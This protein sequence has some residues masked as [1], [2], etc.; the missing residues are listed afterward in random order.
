MSVV[1]LVYACDWQFLEGLQKSDVVGGVYQQLQGS[2]ERGDEVAISLDGVLGP[3][4]HSFGEFGQIVSGVVDRISSS[5]EPLTRFS[6]ALMCLYIDTAPELL[7]KEVDC[8]DAYAT[9]S[10]E[11]VILLAGVCD[12]IEFD[13]LKQAYDAELTSPKFYTGDMRQVSYENFLAYC[14]GWRRCLDEAIE[15]AWGLVCIL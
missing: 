15:R 11:T 7:I 2:V 4:R 14:D 12:Q 1:P 9:L 3:L 13:E 5:E 10:P 8:V 6:G